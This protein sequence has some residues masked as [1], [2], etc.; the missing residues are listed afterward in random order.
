MKRKS[1]IAAL[2]LL[3]AGMQSAKAQ[4]MTV[5][6]VGGQHVDYDVS[7]VE[8]VTFAEGKANSHEWVD[9]ELAG[10]TLWA[11]CNVGAESP[12]ECG[13][14][15]AW[16]ET[17]PK[18][19]YVWD[20][21][22]YCNG[23]G[24]SLTKYCTNSSYGTVDGKAELE[25][26]DDAATFNWGYEWQMP[27]MDQVEELLNTAYTATY[28]TTQNGVY[29]MVFTS[30]SNGN[31]IFLPAAGNKYETDISWKDEGS[32]LS[33]SMMERVPDYAIG[34][35]FSASRQGTSG[36]YRCDGQLVRPVRVK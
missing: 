24:R 12:E 4:K 14:Y 3:M 19:N 6:L 20:T 34:F 30:R 11:T 26:E 9:L 13:D 10:G 17:E 31:S 8:S 21:Y 2:L 35:S 25:P 1:V 32:Y 7:Q 16:G 15:F 27:S 29:G 5:N 36:K 28:M 33:R 23:S 18:T 22:K